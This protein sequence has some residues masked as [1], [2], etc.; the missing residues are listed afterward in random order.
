MRA[1]LEAF[2]SFNAA[3]KET[4]TA[5]LREIESK[6]GIERLEQFS[7]SADTMEN[8]SLLGSFGILSGVAASCAGV[9]R[10]R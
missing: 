3:E 2:D 5:P 6:M 9:F 8:A 10:C 4:L 1:F 7:E